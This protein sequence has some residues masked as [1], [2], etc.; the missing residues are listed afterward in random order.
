MNYE[1]ARAYLAEVARYG[2]VLGLDAMRELMVRMGHPERGQRIVHIAGTNGKGSTL[3]FLNAVLTEQGYRVGCYSSPGVFS[4]RESIR[5]CGCEITE[6]EFAELMT[7]IRVLGD[8]MLRAG[9]AHP[10]VFELETALALQFFKEQCCDIVLL[11]CGLG[12]ARDATNVIDPPVCA[13]FASIS[14]DH[15]DD[16]GENL[17]AIAT[18]KS[19]IIKHGCTV[20]AA[21]GNPEVLNVLKERAQAEGAPITVVAEEPTFLRFDWESGQRFAYNK[22]QWQI[23][24]LGRYQ[25]ANASLAIEVVRALRTQGIEISDEALRAGLRTAVW[26]G[27]FMKIADRPLFLIDGAHNEAGALALAESIRAYLGGRRIVYIVGVLKDKDY[28]S[29]LRIVLPLVDRVITVTPPDNPRAL[30]A[31]LLADAARVLH[32]EVTAA[33]GL[34]EALTLA[35]QEVGAYEKAGEEAA[36]L[37]SGSLSY[38]GALVEAWE[39]QKRAR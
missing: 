29:M 3:A 8:D 13:V 23:G 22:E 30:D 17:A 28:H 26:R 2:S 1:E 18:E 4:Y 39:Q 32:R 11:E 10:T 27:R 16:L 14:R 5:V 20:V 24:M 35:Y 7:R 15:V 31:A 19:G 34:G 37:A 9:K 38:L 25:L 12:G 21:N 36:I 6:Q 33:Q